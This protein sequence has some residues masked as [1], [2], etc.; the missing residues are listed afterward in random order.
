MP[1]IADIFKD[2]GAEY[3]K[4]HPRLLPSHK[5]AIG[6]ISNCRTEEMGS[7]IDI[8]THCGYQHE[9]YHSCCNRSC[10]KCHAG[11]TKMWLEK[12]LPKLL[13]VNY[14]H[15]VFTLPAQLHPFV[16]SNQQALYGRLFK[17]AAYTLSK[18]LADPQFA[19]GVPGMLAVLHTWSSDMN[20]HPHV[21]FLLPEVVLYENRSKWKK[22]KK[23]K[24][25]KNK[26]SKKGFLVPMKIL[27]EV[28]RARYMKLAREALP[29]IKFP[30]SVWSKQW[31]VYPK[32]VD[33]GG[34]TV[35]EYL[36]RY[37]YRVAVTN[38]RIVAYKDERVTFQYKDYKTDTWK[39]MTLPVDQ[40]MHRFLQHVLPLGFHKVRFYGFMASR[41]KCI[42]QSLKFELTKSKE[43]TPQKSS[44]TAPYKNFRCCPRCKRGTMAVVEH[45]FHTKNGLLVVRPPP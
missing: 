25:R 3:K 37:V 45:A 31:L 6:D 15:V 43:S 35:L 7:H 32:Y 24:S 2:H 40:F 12:H 34:Q 19:G 28:F 20:F 41:N 23:K 42:L 30:Q 5:R 16:R 10:P 26:K 18:L 1:D 27:S 44:P 33:Y 4:E 17:A 11:R 38:N 13:P 8:C 14:F 22:I 9:F 29:D 39:R 36:A 21:H